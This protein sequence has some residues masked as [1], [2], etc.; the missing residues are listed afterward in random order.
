[1]HMQ[2]L[3]YKILTNTDSITPIQKHMTK[4]LILVDQLSVEASDI[5]NESQVQ[6]LNIWNMHYMY[7]LKAN[8]D[9]GQCIWDIDRDDED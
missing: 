2:M 7:H 6:S 8:V 5:W 1:M 4:P 3:N 9:V